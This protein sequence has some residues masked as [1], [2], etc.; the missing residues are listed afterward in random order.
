MKNCN[1]C[2]IEKDLS[3]FN[4]SKLSEDGKHR[5]CRE[6]QSSY[7]K[8]YYI[9]NKDLIIPKV[10][11][12]YLDNIEKYRD[13]RKEKYNSNKEYFKDNAKKYI[14]NNP[15]KHRQYQFKS[16]YGIDY[17]EWERLNELQNGKCKICGIVGN[18]TK[19]YLMLDHCHT[20]GKVRGLLC[21]KCNL[22]LGHFKDSIEIMKKAIL[23][24]ED[25]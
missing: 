16:R 21:N 22:A 8:D 6:C 7:N 19:R 14:K 3:E 24:L 23:Y 25:S 12:Y 10:E 18:D 9:K 13:K 11:K 20:T 5:W 2:L 15:N 17:K 1:K 4:N